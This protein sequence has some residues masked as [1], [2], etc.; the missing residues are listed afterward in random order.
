[1]KFLIILAPAFFA[2]A[3]FHANSQ[4][5]ND[6]VVLQ[7]LNLQAQVIA[8]DSTNVLRH[9]DF[10][11]NDEGL[12]FKLETGSEVEHE[13]ESICRDTFLRHYRSLVSDL[14]NL[15]EVVNPHSLLNN[16][17]VKV[18][19]VSNTITS[20]CY[21]GYCARISGKMV[22]LTIFVNTRDDVPLTN[23]LPCAE[24]SESWIFELVN[25]EL[26]FKQLLV[27]G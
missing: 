9:F 14:V 20:E 7:L 16:Q 11:V 4:T 6:S 13:E 2:A 10:P 17:Y 12:Y 1:L 19:L 21:E 27:A 3:G 26:K 8:F 24:H 25:G 15:F 22:E 23:D 5:L 18:T